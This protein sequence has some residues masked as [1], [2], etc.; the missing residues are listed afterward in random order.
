MG[1]QRSCLAA[2]HDA[3]VSVD[4]SEH[5][6]LVIDEELVGPAE[7]EPSVARSGGNS[8]GYFDP[9]VGYV[10]HGGDSD[11]T[12]LDRQHLGVGVF[13]VVW[14]M[15]DRNKKLIALKVV[16]KLEHL[17]RLAEKEVATLQRLREL[18]RKDAE[19]S[20]HIC[21]LREHFTQDGCLCLAFAKLQGSL[22]EAGK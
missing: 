11:Y 7:G 9:P 1:S 8:E 2:P 5:Q 6:S 17:Q 16:R 21:M 19:G 20:A 4:G 12:K 3:Q 18:V 15:A 14:A 22:R 10:F 13:S